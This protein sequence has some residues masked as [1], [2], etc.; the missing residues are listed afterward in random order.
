MSPLYRL[1]IFIFTYFSSPLNGQPYK[2][3]FQLDFSEKG[4]NEIVSKNANWM[5]SL[6]DE[7]GQ[8][9]T[10]QLFSFKNKKQICNIQVPEYGIYT[11]NFYLDL[12]NNQ[13]LD[14]GIL[15]Q[16]IE[17]Y[18]FSNGARNY[19]GIPSIG[20]QQFNFSDESKQI[21]IPINYHFRNPF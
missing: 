7:K 4:N 15:G 16:P 13:K 12:N 14:R 1:T 3:K 2:I 9:I 6:R 20:S 10:Q 8:V 21:N 17:P 11:A 5:I 18:A 19:F